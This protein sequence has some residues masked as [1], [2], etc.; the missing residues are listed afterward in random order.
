VIAQETLKALSTDQLL[1]LEAALSVLASANGN[2]DAALETIAGNRPLSQSNAALI[3]GRCYELEVID[4]LD[5]ASAQKQ[6]MEEF[7]AGKLKQPGFGDFRSEP[8][9]KSIPRRR[10][11]PETTTAAPTEAKGNAD[12]PTPS[13]PPP[14]PDDLPDLTNVVVL[15]TPLNLGNF[16]PKFFNSKHDADGVW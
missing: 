4:G 11:R 13:A 12:L 6:A 9:R 2:F 5:H 1:K 3:G 10:P 14:A 7:A 16:C 15:P 8:P